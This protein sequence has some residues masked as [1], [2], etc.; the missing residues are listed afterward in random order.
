MPVIIRD[1]GKHTVQMAIALSGRRH[2]MITIQTPKE[3]GLVLGA[4][5]KFYGEDHYHA[6]PSP[7][8]PDEFLTPS[9]SAIV[10]C[11][12]EEIASICIGQQLDDDLAKR[13][14]SAVS[15]I[16]DA[17]ERGDTAEAPSA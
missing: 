2:L 5:G 14:A 9:E 6:W 17:A 1:G 11:G 12:L 4:W 16:L 3:G 10:R 15:V 7:H 8:L 13:V